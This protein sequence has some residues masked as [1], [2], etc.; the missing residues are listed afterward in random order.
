MND[1]QSTTCNLEKVAVAIRV[2]YIDNTIPRIK[3]IDDGD[4]FDL[5]TAE[6]VE[7]HKGDFKMINLGVAMELPDG[8]EAHLLAR[9][10]TFKHFGIIQTNGMGI[11]D[12]TFCGNNNIWHLPSLATRDVVIPKH[13]RIAQFRIVPSQFATA[14]VIPVEVDDL[15][16][17]DRGDSGST[18]IGAL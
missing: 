16:N 6:E 2:R 9:S 10:S 17:R 11:V 15:G 14:D 4:W 1:F 13:A 18:G 7:L 5:Y 8:C 3:Q 12:H